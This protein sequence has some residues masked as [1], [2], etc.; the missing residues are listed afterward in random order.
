MG[1][2]VSAYATVFGCL[3]LA[4]AVPGFESRRLSRYSVIN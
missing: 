4:L 2:I 1:A 3:F